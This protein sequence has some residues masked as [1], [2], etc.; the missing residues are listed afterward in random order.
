L[1]GSY[2]R[3]KVSLV[4]GFIWQKKM[5]GETHAKLT[6]WTELPRK[7]SVIKR[8]KVSRTKTIEKKK[9]PKQGLGG[10]PHLMGKGEKE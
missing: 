4:S 7:K 10:D 2:P 1:V 6:S 9:N 3:G 5:A 8:V